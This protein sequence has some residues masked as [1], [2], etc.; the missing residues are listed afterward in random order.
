MC[1]PLEYAPQTV[2]EE[3]DIRSL[4]EKRFAQT[5][6]TVSP[7]ALVY[8]HLTFKKGWHEIGSAFEI[9]IQSSQVPQLSLAPFGPELLYLMPDMFQEAFNWVSCCLPSVL[10]VNTQHSLNDCIEVQASS[11]HSAAQ[12]PC[13]LPVHPGKSQNSYSAPW[14]C[15]CEMHPCTLDFSA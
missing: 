4:L 2:G 7:R 14:R 11:C 12:I 3:G 8:S 10:L 1:L 5:E 9:D 15:T 6:S 13:W